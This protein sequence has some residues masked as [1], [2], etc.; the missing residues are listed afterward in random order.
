MMSVNLQDPVYSPGYSN[1]GLPCT[2]GAHWTPPGT[3]S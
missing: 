3:V 1:P 2:L